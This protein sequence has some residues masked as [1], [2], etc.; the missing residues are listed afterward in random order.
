MSGDQGDDGRRPGTIGDASAS[1]GRT[2]ICGRRALYGRRAGGVAVEDARAETGGVAGRIDGVRHAVGSLGFVSRACGL[3]WGEPA[4]ASDGSAAAAAAA[5]SA[6]GAEGPPPEAPLRAPGDADTGGDGDRI[7]DH[8]GGGTRVF[9][10]REGAFLACF[11]LAD[12]VRP[13][14]RDLVDGLRARGIETTIASGDSLAPVE[15]T[16]EALGVARRLAWPL[17]RGQARP[18][19]TGSP[20]TANAC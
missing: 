14:A 15:R 4:A 7:R 12:S 8:E 17:P 10:A 11:R 1:S 20:R 9:L 2:A 18:R 5:A 19:R 3:P 6:T 13:G 16:G